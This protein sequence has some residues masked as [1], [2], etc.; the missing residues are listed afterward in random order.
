MPLRAD[1]FSSPDSYTD[2]QKLEIYSQVPLGPIF[3][4][5]KNPVKLQAETD[6]LLQ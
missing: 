3:D 5:L 1:N 6:K 4:T 2:S